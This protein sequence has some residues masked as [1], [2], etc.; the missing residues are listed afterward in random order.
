MGKTLWRTYHRRED[1]ARMKR[2]RAALTAMLPVRL[3]CE[4]RRDWRTKAL[5]A[6]LSVV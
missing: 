6:A 1:S 4:R 3:D 5:V 2:L